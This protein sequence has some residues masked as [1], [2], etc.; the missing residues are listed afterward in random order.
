[1]LQIDNL[2]NIVKVIIA[3]QVMIIGPLALEQANKVVGLKV[4]GG[5]N[6]SVEIKEGDPE[7]LLTNLV[8]KYEELFGRASVEVCKDAVKEMKPN[9]E[10]CDLPEI[11]Q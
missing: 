10:A 9:V 4:S 5:N 2:A 1:M 3:H 8:K 11:L 6:L 7:T